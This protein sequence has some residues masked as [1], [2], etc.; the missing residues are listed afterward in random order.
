M[1]LAYLVQSEKKLAMYFERVTHVFVHTTCTSR[2]VDY[3]IGWLF[4]SLIDTLLCTATLFRLCTKQLYFYVQH[5]P[6]N[7]SYTA[8]A[9]TYTCIAYRRARILPYFCNCCL[10][11]MAKENTAAAKGVPHA[12]MLRHHIVTQ[13]RIA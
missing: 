2:R 3:V 6:L 12:K 13:M 11:S 8:H 4:A 9:D 1:T 5:V 10:R 7:T